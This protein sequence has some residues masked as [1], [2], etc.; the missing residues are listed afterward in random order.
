MPPL[1]FSRTAKSDM[2]LIFAFAFYISQYKNDTPDANCR[3]ATY[4]VHDVASLMLVLL[5]WQSG[6][7]AGHRPHRPCEMIK[8]MAARDCDADFTTAKCR[9][10]VLLWM[11][12]GFQICDIGGKRVAAQFCWSDDAFGAV[13]RFCIL[14]YSR[15]DGPY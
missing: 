13:Q 15:H 4:G 6:S 9:E 8:P 7:F 14:V 10:K 3:R 5:A 12:S 11:K 1:Y 2:L